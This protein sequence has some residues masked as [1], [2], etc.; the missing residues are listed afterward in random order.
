MKALVY[1]APNQMEVQ[2]MPEPV[3]GADEVLIQVAAAAVCGSDVHGFQGRSRIRVPPMVMGHEFTGRVR[4]LGAEVQGLS[5]GQRVVIQPLLSC[6]QCVYCRNGHTNAC[7]QRRLI[8]AHEPG[9]FAQYVIVPSKVVYPLPDSL[10]DVEGAL[11]EPLANAVHMLNLAPA[12]TYRDVVI[13]GAGTIGLLT[14]AL[15]RF[16]GARH[17]VATDV[18]GEKLRIAEQLGADATLDARK[19]DTTDRVLSM[20]GGGAGLVIDTAGFT[21]TRQQAIAVAAPEAT[22]VLLGLGEPS[23]DLPILDVIN[24][25]VS[26]RGSY[27]CTD[28]EFRRSIDLLADRRISVGSWIETAP[29][30]EGPASFERLAS[31]APGLVKIVFDM[32]L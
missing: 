3:P 24:R 18:D 21:V 8:G 26:V 11:V 22:V 28:L 2:D 27:S 31:H 29:L 15:A 20:T 30:G 10:S 5:I 13:L 32:K 6:G 1:A 4:S 17:V 23:S 14:V 16:N 9:A 19:A 12:E 7:P 25:E